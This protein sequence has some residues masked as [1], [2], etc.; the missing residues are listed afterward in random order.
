MAYERFSTTRIRSMILFACSASARG[1]EQGLSI[2]L[3]LDF[4]VFAGGDLIYGGFEVTIEKNRRENH[5][6]K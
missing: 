5:H 6:V 2:T 4:D 1:F 3:Y